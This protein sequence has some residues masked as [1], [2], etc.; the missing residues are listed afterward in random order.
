MSD[1]FYNL[2]QKIQTLSTRL[3]KDGKKYIHS[4]VNKGE[5]IGYT[6]K[7]QF[8]IE[9]LK[10]ELKQKYTNLGKY[11]SDEKISKSITDF[12]YNSKF[13][14]LVNDIN[15]IKLYIYDLQHQKNNNNDEIK[16]DI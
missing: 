6:G 15:K 14:E 7:I 4:A 12:S 5:K 1:F 13:L 10:W 9:K 16:N 8:E 3:A 2:T 11:I